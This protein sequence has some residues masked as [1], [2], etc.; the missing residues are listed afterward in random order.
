MRPFRCLQKAYYLLLI[1]ILNVTKSKDIVNLNIYA[2]TIAAFFIT[3][4]QS[5]TELLILLTNIFRAG[6]ILS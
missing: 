3:L 4:C 2:I 1:H 5:K 6:T